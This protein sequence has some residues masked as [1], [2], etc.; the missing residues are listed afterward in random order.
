MYFV[1][2][3][4]LSNIR[5]F[6]TVFAGCSQVAGKKERA[7]ILILYIHF[8]HTSFYGGEAVLLIIEALELGVGT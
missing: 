1:F 8:Q 2:L 4:H 7:V 3:K 6:D 5:L